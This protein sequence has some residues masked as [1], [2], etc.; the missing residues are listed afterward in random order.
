MLLIISSLHSFFTLA[1][2]SS[3]ALIL[4]CSVYKYLHSP[5]NIL[6]KQK[7]SAKHN[8]DII[9]LVRLLYILPLFHLI[10]SSP[11][12]QSLCHD[13][14]SS[15]LLQFKESFIINYSAS[16]DPVAYPRIR[17]WRLEGENS[18]C[19][20]WVGY[21]SGIPIPYPKSLPIDT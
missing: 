17:S 8:Q 4:W 20:S 18:D 1:L 7:M 2:L 3:L 21:G 9:M 13:D 11:S 6:N 15:A 10:H 12:K 14:E 19:C 5:T 16:S